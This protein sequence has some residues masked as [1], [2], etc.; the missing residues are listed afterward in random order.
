MF[1]E[2]DLTHVRQGYLISKCFP[3]LGYKF[4]IVF[5]GSYTYTNTDDLQIL[6]KATS[7]A[8]VLWH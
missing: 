1:C 2:T 7:Q 8:E 4:T 3:V 6:F 5:N